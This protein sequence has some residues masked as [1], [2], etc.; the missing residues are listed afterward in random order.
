PDADQAYLSRSHVVEQVRHSRRAREQDGVGR[1]LLV[2]VTLAGPTRAQFHE[3]VIL[4][5]QRQQPMEEQKL[6]P[7]LKMGRLQTNRAKQQVDPL[8]G[9][10]LATATP[11]LFEVEAR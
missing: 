5:A 6:E 1:K 4:L 11:V 3:V 10:E 2:G 7:P 9:G 8:V